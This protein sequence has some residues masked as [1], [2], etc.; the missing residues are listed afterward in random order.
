M[1]RFTRTSAHRDA[2][3]G[4]RMRDLEVCQICGSTDNVQGHHIFDLSLGGAAN[5]D[6]IV[7]LCSVCHQKVHRGLIDISVG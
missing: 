6:N 1:S 5:I 4:G 7:T 2:Q 3:R